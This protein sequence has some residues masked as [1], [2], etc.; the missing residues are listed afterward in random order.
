[1][2]DGGWIGILL[3]G[4]S[5]N[6]GRGTGV[7]FDFTIDPVSEEEYVLH[8][9]WYDLYEGTK[10]ASNSSLT[11]EMSGQ[12][13][14]SFGAI[15]NLDVETTDL[16]IETTVFVERIPKCLKKLISYCFR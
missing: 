8:Y 9:R 12:L 5:V 4:Q 7:T 10:R 14:G 11:E 15:T 6:Y 13:E 2:A 16:R 3:P 1:M